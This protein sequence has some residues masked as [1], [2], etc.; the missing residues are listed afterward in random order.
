MNRLAYTI[1]VRV[2]IE[3]GAVLGPIQTRSGKRFKSG[4]KE[5]G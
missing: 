3:Y 1:L 5:S 2:I 4:A